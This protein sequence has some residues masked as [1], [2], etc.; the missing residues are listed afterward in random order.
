MK[1]GLQMTASATTILIDFILSVE[2]LIKFSLIIILGYIVYRIFRT[3][4]WF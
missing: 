3:S 4:T 2:L 1:G